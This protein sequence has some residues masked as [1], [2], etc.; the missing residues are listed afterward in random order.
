MK[1]LSSWTFTL[2]LLST[3]FRTS[4]LSLSLQQKPSSWDDHPE[5][6]A[7]LEAYGYIISRVTQKDNDIA[8]LIGSSWIYYRNGRMLSEESFQDQDQYQ[9]IFY[10]YP[11]GSLTELPEYEELPK[12]S[13]DFLDHLFGTAERELSE[14]CDWVPFLNH[15]AYVNHFCAEALR[16]V[17]GEILEAA[18][19]DSAVRT[20]I[21][22]LK[23]IY[24]FKQRKISGSNNV[25]Y[26][27]YGLALDLVPNSYEGKQ[28]NWKWSSV[29]FK[30]WHLIPLAKRWSP[31]Q[32]VIDAFEHNGFVWGGKWSHFDTIHFEYVP[33]II[34][35]ARRKN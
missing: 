7:L 20:Y 8:F 27:F 28:V 33:E 3:F 11:L 19:S 17:E 5:I 14:Q 22:S 24:S 21:D 31:P 13:S 12:R 25:S 35:L 26:H 32:K 29:Y 9:S 6:S 10:D 2:L 23:I 15:K 16:K 1:T 4:T 30:E 34:G 18:E